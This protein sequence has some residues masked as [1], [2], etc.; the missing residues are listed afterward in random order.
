VADVDEAQG[1]HALQGLA[2]GLAI[3]PQLF[4]Q[5]SLRREG[6]AGGDAARHDLGGELLENGIGERSPLDGL[7][8][9]GV[10]LARLRSAGQL[11]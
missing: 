6:V 2:D 10:M 4:G 3:H 1:V 5:G 7:E 9:H 11:V 8:S